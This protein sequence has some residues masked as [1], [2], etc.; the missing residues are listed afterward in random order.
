MAEPRSL[1][2]PG[3]PAEAHLPF[4]LFSQRFHDTTFNI[5][6]YA[7]IQKVVQRMILETTFNLHNHRNTSESSSVLHMVMKYHFIV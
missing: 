4:H 7:R 2:L 1:S 5:F 3:H 6:L